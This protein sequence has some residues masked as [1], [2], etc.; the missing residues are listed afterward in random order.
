MRSNKAV[1]SPLVFRTRQSY[2]LYDM[3][4]QRRVLWR[5]GI[6]YRTLK[7]RVVTRPCRWGLCLHL[8]DQCSSSRPALSIEL[9]P[10]ESELS[11]KSSQPD[12]G[13][14]LCTGGAGEVTENYV[15]NR[16]SR[17]RFTHDSPLRAL[18]SI[19]HVHGSV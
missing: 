10:R 19:Q 11:Q 2:N 18:K 5:Q 6:G 4:H 14:W 15:R 3:Q 13:A 7:A 17:R 1:L 9:V 8:P 12:S 16:S